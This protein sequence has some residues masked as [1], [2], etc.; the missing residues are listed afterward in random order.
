MVLKQDGSGL[1]LAATDFIIGLDVGMF[2][3]TIRIY[4]CDQYTREFCDVR[5]NV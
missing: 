3:R 1:P 4:D 5:Y 2:G